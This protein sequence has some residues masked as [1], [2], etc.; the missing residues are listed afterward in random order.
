[1]DQSGS[2]DTP[3]NVPSIV[4]AAENGDLE[5]VKIYIEIGD[6]VNESDDEIIFTFLGE[7]LCL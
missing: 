4:E 1:M 5:M 7:P 2:D 3:Q 6:D